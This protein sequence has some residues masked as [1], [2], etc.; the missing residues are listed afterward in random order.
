M[1]RIVMAT[2]L[3]AG[4]AC[5]AHAGLVTVGFNDFDASPEFS[6]ANYRERR[7]LDGSVAEMLTLVQRLG[8]RHLF[9]Q[10]LALHL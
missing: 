8:G 5:T 2:V 3:T 6:Y 7:L 10:Q 9:F 4:F 1:K